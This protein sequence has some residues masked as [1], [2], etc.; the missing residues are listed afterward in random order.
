MTFVKLVACELRARLNFLP[1][2]MPPMFMGCLSSHMM[3]RDS[4]D[5]ASSVAI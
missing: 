3:D 2:K 1:S 5:V 4:R